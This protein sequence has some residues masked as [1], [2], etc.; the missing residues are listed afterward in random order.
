MAGTVVLTK[1]QQ[2]PLTKYTL[3]WT[4][5]AGGAV[6]GNPFAVHGT[7]AQVRVV[8]N[9]G[10]TQPSDQYDMTLVDANSID[11]LDGEGANLS[12]STGDIFLCDPLIFVDTSLDLVIAAAGSAKTGTVEVWVRA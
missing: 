6:S 9:T 2:G 3:A 8:P 5:S 12:N 10:A 11:V 4:S 1:D 7:L